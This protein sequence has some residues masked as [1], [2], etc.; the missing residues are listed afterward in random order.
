VEAKP[1]PGIRADQ[2]VSTVQLAELVG[3]SRRRLLQ[4]AGSR[5]VHPVQMIGKSWLWSKDQ[6]AALIPNPVG[7]YLGARP[8]KAKPVPTGPKKKR[9]RPPKVR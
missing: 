8:K 5:G 3:V 7:V 1:I 6:A 2:L 9:G 4:I